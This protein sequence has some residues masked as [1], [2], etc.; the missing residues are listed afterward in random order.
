MASAHDWWVKEKKLLL[1]L[2]F[3]TRYAFLELNI[4][5]SSP[6]CV[7]TT[8]LLDESQES[9]VTKLSVSPLPM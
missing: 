8:I 6:V 5:L 7:P 3:S 2:R 9:E 4:I 1:L